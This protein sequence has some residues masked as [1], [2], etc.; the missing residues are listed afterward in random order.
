MTETIRKFKWYRVDFIAKVE[1]SIIYELGPCYYGYFDSRDDAERQVAEKLKRIYP[2][3]LVSRIRASLIC[4]HHTNGWHK[5]DEGFD[6]EI[7]PQNERSFE[8]M[9]I[10]DAKKKLAECTRIG[11]QRDSALG[12]FNCKMKQGFDHM[13]SYIYVL[14][15]LVGEQPPLDSS[16][17]PF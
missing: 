2:G 15:V 13:E 9:T 12:L 3:V 14:K 11:V 5:W 10:E 4:Y 6:A 1:G 7:Y 16:G 8:M 17:G